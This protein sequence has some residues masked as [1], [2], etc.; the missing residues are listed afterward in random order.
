[1]NCKYCQSTNTIK[2]GTYTDTDGIEIQRYYCKDC[3]RKFVPNTL[4]KMQTPVD[5]VSAALRMYYSGMSLDGIQ[6]Q[7]QQQFNNKVA[8]STVYYWIV[9]FTKEAIMRSE[10]YHPD[11]LE[12]VRK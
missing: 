5:Q 8:K 2:F 1:M 9:K 3:K 10:I 12:H 4:P 6:D 7:L 11:I